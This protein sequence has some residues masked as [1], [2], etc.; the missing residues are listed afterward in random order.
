MH[1]DRVRAAAQHSYIALEIDQTPFGFGGRRA[2][3]TTING[4]IPGPLLRFREGERAEIRVTN[5]LKEDTS[6]HWHGLL[7]P[8]AMDGVPGVNFPG[9]HPG[10]TFVY[11]FPL[12]QNGTYWYHSH[13]NFQEQ[14][15]HYGPLIIDPSEP[16]AFEYDREFVVMLSDWSF[17]DPRRILDNLKKQSSYYNL[18]RRTLGDFFRDVDRDGLRA[19]LAD[20]LEWGKMRMS[21]I[22]ISDVTGSTYTYLMNGLPAA[23]NWTALFRPGERVRLRFINASA[24]TYF[25]V[26]VAGL[27]MT[28]VQ[29]SGQ[30]VQP[31]PTDEFR[32]EIA[33]TLDVI[34]EPKEDKAFTIFAESM[35]RS[36]FTRG[37]LAP[38]SGMS[39][40]VPRRRP[41]PTLSMMDMGMGMGMGG[42]SGMA[43][44][45][46]S[47]AAMP[48]M[49]EGANSS[50]K[51]ASEMRRLSDSVTAVGD[52]AHRDMQAHAAS[53]HDMAAMTP[54]PS[55]TGFEGQLRDGT[56]IRAA[57]SR[58]PGTLPSAVAHGPDKHGSGNAATPMETR[59]RLSE[60]GAGLGEDGWRV[61]VLTDLKRLTPPEELAPPVRE[62]ELHLTGNME[63]YMWSINGIKFSD[64]LEHIPLNHGERF[65]LVIVNDTMM[66]HPMHLHGM[67]MELE[68]GHGP[69]CPFVHTINVKPAERVSLLATPMDPGPWA[70]H[71]HILFHMD[72]G[73]FRVFHVSE[74]GG[75]LTTPGGTPR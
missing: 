40:P 72:V 13:S 1:A 17:E 11:Q 44:G 9:I 49:Q 6:I 61:L 70:F 53:G 36:G 64:A 59:S 62:I 47:D 26:R 43:M 60:P 4:S 25:D 19:T 38:G 54:S 12:R 66:A 21:P 67:Y 45:A 37:T 30:N 18:Q 35:D 51:A 31:V 63:R 71:C 15:G 32:L 65:R 20:R 56:I 5:R 29:V 57:D 28:V 46:Q 23:A 58:A 52:S 69:A 14:V 7:V 34:V 22:D 41:R 73:M 2:I 8:N 16:E 39:A 48:G 10:E 75:A 24:G 3:A 50:A 55:P 33:Q 27:E 42:H 68:N 74:P